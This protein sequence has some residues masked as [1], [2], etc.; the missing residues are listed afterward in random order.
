MG[1]YPVRSEWCL[2]RLEQGLS[3]EVYTAGERSSGIGAATAGSAKLQE[4]PLH[5]A[6]APAVGSQQQV[7][8]FME[9]LVAPSLLGRTPG[10]EG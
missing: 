6:T 8:S 3:Q 9:N 1:S 2:A 4:V 5:R 10:R 7:V